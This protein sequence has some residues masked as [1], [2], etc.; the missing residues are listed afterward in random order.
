[1]DRKKD[2]N[3]STAGLLVQT[4]GAMPRPWYMQ[5]DFRQYTVLTVLGETMATVGLS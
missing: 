2:E 5:R 4:C 3:K 1:M